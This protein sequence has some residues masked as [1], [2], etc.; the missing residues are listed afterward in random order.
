MVSV[1]PASSMKFTFLSF[2]A[3]QSQNL[4]RDGVP[5]E[6]KGEEKCVLA[7]ELLCTRH[8]DEG[9]QSSR[10]KEETGALKH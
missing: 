1:L 3:Y 5:W 4:K 9:L 7:T 8:C 6:R 2:Y 10:P